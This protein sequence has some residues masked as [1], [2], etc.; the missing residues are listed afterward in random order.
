MEDAEEKLSSMTVAELKELA[1]EKKISLKGLKKKKEIITAISKFERS[2]EVLDQGSSGEEMAEGPEDVEEDINEIMADTQEAIAITESDRMIDEEKISEKLE[3]ARNGMLDFNTLLQYLETLPK[4]FDKKDYALA[5]YQV[6]AAERI[7][8]RVFSGWQSWAVA[9]IISASEKM[10]EELESIGY[11][12]KEQRHLTKIAKRAFGD[13]MQES[14][15]ESALT[16]QKSVSAAFEKRMADVN[17]RLSQLEGD[18][19]KI[20]EIGANV[21]DASQLLVSARNML[22]KYDHLGAEKRLLEAESSIEMAKTERIQQINDYFPRVESLIEDGKSLGADMSEAEHLLKLAHDSFEREDYLMTGELLGK[23]EAGA[24]EGQEEQI[25]KAMNLRRTQIAKATEIINYNEPFVREAAAYG[26]DI[27]QA[28]EFIRQAKTAL[29]RDDYVEGLRLAN[30]LKRFVA[31]LK[32]EIMDIRARRGVTIPE[33]GICS[34][35]GS[36]KLSFSDNGTGVCEA[37][38]YSFIWLRLQPAARAPKPTAQTA[39]P[40]NTGPAGNTGTNICPRCGSPMNFVDGVGLVCPNCGF[41]RAVSVK[42]KA[43][44]K[45]GLFH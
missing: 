5:L 9:W 42:K 37:C 39:P 13:D 21:S 18:I 34:K 6:M 29:S 45:R 40:S 11:D 22:L 15:R 31:G 35:C 27:G 26:L 16:L 38:G 43:A 41:T 25:K 24:L 19:A 10:I 8:E 1:R 36:D 30:E 32:P 28:S 17:E 3:D 2:A 44:K 7:S 33:K 12:M 14:M 20:N 4:T 23:A